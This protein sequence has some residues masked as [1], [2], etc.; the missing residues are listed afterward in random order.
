MRQMAQMT[1]EDMMKMIEPGK[2]PSI[3]GGCPIQNNC[4]RRSKQLLYCAL[5][6]S[7]T[8]ITEEKGCIC[9]SYHLLNRW[10]SIISFSVQ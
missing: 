1:E 6:K 10:G 9:P 8:C 5:G 3:C 2:K 4:A 7:P